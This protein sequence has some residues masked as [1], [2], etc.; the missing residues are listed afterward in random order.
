MTRPTKRRKGAGPGLQRRRARYR[1]ARWSKDPRRRLPDPP[2]RVLA[3]AYRAYLRSPTDGTTWTSH[4]HTLAAARVV[5]RWE[6]ARVNYPFLE[7]AP[8]VR[9]WEKFAE[10][11]VARRKRT[12]A[13]VARRG[14]R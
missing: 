13:R 5:L 9:R 7:S 10:K 2:E 12:R 8:F 3:E 6:R 11:E 4:P 14:G 1:V